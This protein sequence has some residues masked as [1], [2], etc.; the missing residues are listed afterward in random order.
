MTQSPFLVDGQVT[1]E[2]IK[3]QELVQYMLVVLSEK[4]KYIIQQRFSLESDKKQ[5]LEE[6]GQHFG[7]TRERV[8][9]IE[10]A[11]LKKLA[12]SAQNSNIRVLTSFAKTL[13]EKEGGVLKDSSFKSLLVNILPNV[14]ADQLQ[15]LH[16]AL[17][18]DSEIHFEPNTL[19]FHPYWRLTSIPEAKVKRVIDRGLQTLKKN[20]QVLS[21]ERLSSKIVETV[22]MDLS[23]NATQRILEVCKD[24]KFTSEGVGLASWRHIHPR[25]LRDKILF[26]FN[27]E[28]KPLHFRKITQHI[29]EHHFDLKN[30]NHQA[31][32][33]ELIRNEQFIL[34]GRGI[35]ALKEWG[36]EAG[37]VAEVI[38]DILKEGVPMTREEVT[39]AVLERRQ[40]K[41]ITIYLNLKNKE[42]FSRV[43]RNH[44]T[45]KSLAQ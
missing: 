29:V 4:E 3:L 23:A 34:I 20:K 10:K 11:A 30:I 26:I 15:E 31:V 39:K 38:Q 25:T 19:K 17:V 24:C 35:Y 12:R 8:R 45:L 2:N 1:A 36:F 37:T 9:Q 6:I 33:N 27:K 28:K 42:L 32:H 41:S 21:S 18:L 7:I 14:D 43:G 5:T 40:V 16:L 22:K 44:Y 13:L